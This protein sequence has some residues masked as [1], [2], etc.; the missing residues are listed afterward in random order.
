[1]W[2]NY[3]VVQMFILDEPYFAYIEMQAGTALPHAAPS[4]EVN[5]YAAAD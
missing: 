2:Y 4:N 5:K 1:M 3:C